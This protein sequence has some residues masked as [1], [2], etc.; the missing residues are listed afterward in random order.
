MHHTSEENR[1]TLWVAP[2]LS[3][4]EMTEL[5]LPNDTN[6]WESPGRKAHALD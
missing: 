5:L 1:E 4:V 6:L 2:R 3:Q